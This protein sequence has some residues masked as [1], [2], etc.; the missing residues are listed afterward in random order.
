MQSG[1]WRRSLSA[2]EFVAC[3]RPVCAVAVLLAAVATGCVP[4]DKLNSKASRTSVAFESIDGPPAGVFHKLVQSL[5]DEAQARRLAVV[6]REQ[7]S[8]YRVRGYL[9]AHVAGGY[10]SI[11]WVWDVYDADQHRALRIAGQEPGGRAGRDA[12]TAADDELLQRIAR[13][14]LDQLVAFLD[15]PEAVDQASPDETGA[16]SIA[17][18]EDSP[19][20]AGIFRLYGTTGKGEQAPE[21]APAAAE[22]AAVPLP[23]PRPAALSRRPAG[24]LAF[25]RPQ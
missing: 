7:P 2:R 14:G 19:E 23:R 21:A 5:N 16:F 18:A 13:S 12:W 25:A 10:T 4:D 8:R 3:R 1:A 9:A 24:P 17:G 11:A 20:S 15:A 22:P 6:S